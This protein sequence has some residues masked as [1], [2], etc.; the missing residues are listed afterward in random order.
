M[1]KKECCSYCG[2]PLRKKF[3]FNSI[4]VTPTIYKCDRWWCDLLKDWGILK[5]NWSEED[6]KNIK[7]LNNVLR[8]YLG[9]RTT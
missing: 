5:L 4:F 9:R 2:K 6:A 8:Y 7:K 1:A 3:S